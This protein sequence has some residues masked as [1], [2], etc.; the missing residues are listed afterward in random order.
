[1]WDT[2]KDF[3]FRVLMTLL[4]IGSIIMALTMVYTFFTETSGMWEKSDL[5][6]VESKFTHKG[7]YFSNRY[8]VQLENKET[9]SVFKYTFK[10]IE[11]GDSFQPFFQSVSWKDF[12][13]ILCGTSIVFIGFISLAY[14]LAVHTFPNM[15][16]MRTLENKRNQLVTWIISSFR[17]NE[18]R[19][20]K[21]IKG[22]FI[23]L[24]F[25]LSV[26]YILM[27]KNVITSLIPSD[28]EKAIAEVQDSEIVKHT[29][30]GGG[31]NTYTLTYTFKDKD[32]QSY[33]TKKDVSRYTYHLYANE[34]FIPI[35]Y[36]KT[37]PNDTFIDIRSS[38]EVISAILRFSTFVFLLNASLLIY[39]IKKYME[40]WGIPFLNKRRK[41]QCKV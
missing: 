19:R 11:E 9:H 21:W 29:G 30:R 3:L 17:K 25:L 8:V 5:Q 23:T 1:M 13:L 34:M 32:N 38:R 41:K 14:F 6:I 18:E 16:L 20:E 12:W 40:K 33:R 7:L 2:V 37:F 22:L 24:I 28:K 10:K 15:R 39:F 36:K 4:F 35:L 31:S 27:T 26:P